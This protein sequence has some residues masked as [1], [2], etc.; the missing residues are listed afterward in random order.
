MRRLLRQLIR[1]ER[2][3]AAVEFALVGPP[4]LLTLLSIIELGLILTTQAQLD[5]AAR[6]AARLILTGQVAAAGNTIGTFQTALCNNM[7]MLLNSATCTNNV[8]IDVVS[9]PNTA[10]FAGLTFPACSSNAGSGGSNP[11]PFNPGTCGNI[12]AVQV[13]YNR[14]FIVPWVGAML[15]VASNSQNATIQSTVVFQN[16]PFCT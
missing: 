16:E 8:L 6:T 7:T 10:N 14:P 2:G 11:C 1:D 5:G 9:S 3:A 13:V 15:S 4:F 12:V